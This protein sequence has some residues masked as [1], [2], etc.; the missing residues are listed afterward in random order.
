MSAQPKW[1]FVA[2]LGDVSP[3]EYGGYFVYRDITKVYAPEAELLREPEDGR[4]HDSAAR[5]TVYRFTLEPCTFIDGILS[6]N[7]YHPSRPAWFAGTEPERELR[8]QDTTYLRDLAEFI[9]ADVKDLITDFCSD[10]PIRRAQ[11][12]RVVG[13]YHGYENLDSDPLVLTRAEVKK[14]YRRLIK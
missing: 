13:D 9:G 12:W 6:D 2:N 4:D 10:D 11:A 3:L 7:P 14:R 8:P 5:W 1:R